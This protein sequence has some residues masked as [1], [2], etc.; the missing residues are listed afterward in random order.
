M[1]VNS[2]SLSNLFNG[3]K[4]AFN[5]GFD[6]APSTMDRIA[7]TVP[8]KAREEQ[9]GWLGVL[10]KIREWIGDRVIESLTLHGFTLKNR[11]FESTIS[12][13]RDDIEDDQYG[14]LSP[15]VGE[16][17]R[18]AKQHPDELV[19]TLLANGFTSLCYDG[20][21][22]FDTDH[23][24]TDATGTPTSQSNFQAGA[25]SAWYLLDGSRALKPLV[26]Q[27]REPYSF[28]S[29]TNM[30]DENVFM[31]NEY[32]YGVRARANA[33]YGL[34]Q[35]IYASKD[36]L[37]ATNY[38][39]AR[40][41]MIGRTGDNGKKLGIV[42]NILLVPPSLEEAGRTLVLS[43]NNAAGASNPWKGTATLIMTP[44]LD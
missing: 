16:M 36:T 22:F 4:T 44:W 25:G 7:M 41:A 11:T 5:E 20:Q 34:W 28:Q 6:G 18:N 32:I 1:L 35:L 13:S 40:A 39:A 33:G 26:F 10:P 3:F 8:S 17:G 23:P 27:K 12:V 19:Y 24:V 29:L 42:P 2:E 38:A 30:N 43:E 9:Y 37:D 15:L 31:R 14:V 21:Y